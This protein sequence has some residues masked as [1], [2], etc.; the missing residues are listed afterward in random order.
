MGG[1]TVSSA[2]VDAGFGWVD[3]DLRAVQE[4]RAT[5]KR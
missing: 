4:F 5:G 3:G 1:E 2:A